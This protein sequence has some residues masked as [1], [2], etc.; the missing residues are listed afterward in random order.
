MNHRRPNPGELTPDDLFRPESEP[1]AAYA[2][3]QPHHLAP[4]PQAAATQ[5][6]PPMP[7][8]PQAPYGQPQQGYEQP[9]S[10]YAQQQGGYQDSGSYADGGYS[11]GGY[12]GGGYEE[13]QEPPRSGPSM[14]AIAI[15]VVAACAVVGIGMGAMLGGGTSSASPQ[16]SGSAVSQPTAAK[17][18]GAAKGISPQAQALSAL[19]DTAA[20]NRQSVVAA[21]ENI[22]ACSGLPQDQQ[23]LTAASQARANLVTQLAALKVDQLQQGA[24]LVDA[25]T[26]GWQASQQADEHY[27]AWAAASVGPCQ[28]HHHPQAGGEGA[29]GNNASG[30]ATSA[31]KQASALWNAIAA[32][33]SLP[34]KTYS[35]L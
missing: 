27:A 18:G 20:N 19:L 12:A 4:E 34:A 14:R 2:E 9:Y 33:N 6:L 21:V 26:R 28:K 25:L 30:D 23:T 22:K 32:A 31:K 17:D 35:Q 5:F 29:A 11:D 1:T 3:Q 16:A 15:G 10:P 7:A 8:A 13:E 24:A